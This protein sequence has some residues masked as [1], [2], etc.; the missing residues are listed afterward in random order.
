MSHLSGKN[1][2]IIIGNTAVN[3]ENMTATITDNSTFAS[4]N[5]VPDGDIDGDV[6]CEGELE[7]SLKEFKKLNDQ[8]QTAGS[9]KDLG[10]FDIVC[11]GSFGEQ[12]EK[13][14]LFGCKL[15][16]SDL[17]SIDPKAAE[18]VKRKVPFY[19]TSPD[20]VRINGVPYLR[21]TDT[22]GL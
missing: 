3:V 4:T 7:F 5:G 15:K 13:L 1:F 8:A 21:K 6:S 17:V 20:F 12:S 19:V 10:A 11:S 18:K 9:W 14:E 2:H 22:Q 16:I